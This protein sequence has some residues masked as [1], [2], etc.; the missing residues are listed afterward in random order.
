[1]SETRRNEPARPVFRIPLLLAASTALALGA[2]LA[3]DAALCRGF[4]WL[5]LGAP[6]LVVAWGFGR[7]P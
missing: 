1:M 5:G 3:S 4:A 2:A 7:A 6:L